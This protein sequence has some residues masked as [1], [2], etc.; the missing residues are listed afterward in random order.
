MGSVFQ[1]PVSVRTQGLDGGCGHDTTLT[2][3]PRLMREPRAPCVAGM[4]QKQAGYF[5]TCGELGAE[6]MSSPNAHALTPSG[7]A[8]GGAR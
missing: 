6:R 3:S 8:F 2:P 1:K 4:L 5:L 7:M